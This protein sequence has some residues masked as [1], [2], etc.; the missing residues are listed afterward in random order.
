M[1]ELPDLV[2]VTETATALRVSK[3]TVYRMIEEG[4]LPSVRI[5][6]RNIRIPFPALKAYLEER[7]R[8]TATQA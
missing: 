4:E 8:G 3:M 6:R 5:G 1:P 7:T 2:T